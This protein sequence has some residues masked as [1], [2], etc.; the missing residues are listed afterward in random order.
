MSSS[1]SKLAVLWCTTNSGKSPGSVECIFPEDCERLQRWPA[2]IPSHGPLYLSPASFLM[3]LVYAEHLGLLPFNKFFS[4]W[5]ACHHR[6]LCFCYKAVSLLHTQFKLSKNPFKG[7]PNDGIVLFNVRSENV[8]ICFF[9]CV[10]TAGM[11]W[12]EGAEQFC[13]ILDNR[14]VQMFPS[15][16]GW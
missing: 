16:V 2:S 1:D 11:K 13:K 9:P 12:I 6:A 3:S 8:T 14:E 4:L 5:F 10:R 15:A 7:P